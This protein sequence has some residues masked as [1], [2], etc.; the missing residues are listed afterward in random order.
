[1]KYSVIIPTHNEAENIGKAISVL[2]KQSVSRKDFEIIVVDNLSTDNTFEAARKAG[3]DKVIKENIK[4]TNIARQTGFKNS[5]GEIVAFLDADCEP[6]PNWLELIDK[7]L[8]SGEIKAVSGPFDYGFTGLT[9]KLDYI[10]TRKILPNIPA[11]LHFLFR[12]KAGVIIGGNFAARRNVI[13]AIGGL[14]PLAFWGDDVAIAMLISRRVGKVVF[15]PKLIVKSSPR[16][17]EKTGMANLLFRYIGA[18]LK[19]FFSKEFA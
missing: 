11:L 12:K 1:M 16:R 2:N 5:Q 14:P 15:N 9:K 8:A 17:F 10:Y 3:A 13:E 6:L 19:I 18:Y 7:D 4:G